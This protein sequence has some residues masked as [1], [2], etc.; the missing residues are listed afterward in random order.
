MYRLKTFLTLPVALLTV[1]LMIP[2]RQAGEAQTETVTDPRDLG[3]ILFITD[4]PG[5]CSDRACKR[6]VDLLASL[7]K[8]SHKLLTV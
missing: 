7:V 3:P 1:A 5:I 2:S 6:A 8:G 4:R